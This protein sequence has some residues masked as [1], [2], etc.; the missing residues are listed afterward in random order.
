MKQLHRI[1]RI[2]CLFAFLIYAVT[3]CS[4]CDSA[5]DGPTAEELL[6]AKRQRESEWIAK[7]KTP[8]ERLSGAKQFVADGNPVAAEA[9]LRP[10]LISIP[11]NPSVL[12]IWA[13]IQAT[14]GRKTQ[15]IETLE[16]VDDS[17]PE[18]KAQALW[19]ASQWLIDLGEFTRAENSLI[20]LIALPGDQSEAL[21]TLSTILNN[22]GRRREA[23]VH[24]ESLAKAGQ[25][26]E[27]ELIAMITLGNPFL[28]QSMPKPD[29]GSDLVPALLVMSREL[30]S[31]GDFAGAARLTAKLAEAFPESTQI[32][33]FLG[34]VYSDQQDNEKLRQWVSQVPSGIEIEAEYWHA[35]GILM[36]LE[37]RPREAVRCFLETVLRDQTNRPAYL[38][39]AQLLK[40]LGQDE[41]A[42]ECLQRSEAI[43]ETSKI[44]R[45]LGFERG[46]SDQLHRIADLL[47]QLRRP[48]E[49][50]A[51]RLIALKQQGAD[52][53]EIQQLE[54]SRQ[55]LLESIE[56][57]A[58]S[59]RTSEA[60]LLCGLDRTQWP[61]PAQDFSAQ[62]TS[63]SLATPAT[64]Q[65]KAISLVNISNQIGLDFQYKNGQATESNELY[66]HQVTG[67]GVGVIDYDLDGWPDLYLTQGGGDAFSDDSNLEDE[68]FRNDSG[69][70]WQSIG[71]A[72]GIDNLGYGQGVA[73][74]DLNQDGWLDIL[75]AN[76]GVNVLYQNNGD[77]SFTRRKLPTHPREGGGWTTSIACG[78]ITGDHLPEIIETNYLDDLSGLTV[79]C[80]SGSI[81]CNPAQF[82]PAADCLLSIQP[83]GSI[84]WNETCAGMKEKSNYGFGIVIADFDQK[85]GNEV[86]ITN[87]TRNNHYWVR[88]NPSGQAGVNQLVE[89]ASIL[90]CAA[91]QN[92][93]AR[94]CMGIAFGDFDRNL[95]LDLYVTNFW[96]QAADLYLL[97]PNGSFTPGNYKLGLFEDS[98]DTVGWGAQAADFDHD[99]WLDLAVL[100]G[101]VTDLSQ[102][103]QPYEMRPQLFQGGAGGFNAVQPDRRSEPNYWTRPALG[104][105]L[106]LIDW[107][108]DGR[109]DLIAN[110]LDQPIALL[111]NQ[112][113]TIG[114]NSIRIELV[115]TLSE[116]DAIGATVTVK[117]R[118]ESWRAWMTGGDGFLCSN[119]NQLHFGVGQ[120]STV[121][122]ITIHWPTGLEQTFRNLATDETY[123]AVEG[124]DDLMER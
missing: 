52:D 114:D 43:G 63:P 46:T 83:D 102:R 84:V 39:L 80:G 78:D 10:L 42:Q 106:A 13:E 96:K 45:S 16:A 71:K 41:L 17:E 4:G 1:W 72:A 101:H 23:G 111:E 77:G 5:S 105:T 18:K 49:S 73:A 21:R 85:P 47:E 88:Q 24:L 97:Q 56:Q 29:F 51:W 54:K 61:L 108:Q 14:S 12:L 28:D 40:Q 11:N 57:N 120:R 79:S 3:L 58:E 66:I 37:N 86:F 100:N 32:Q 122:S 26:Q 112:T 107:N 38:A 103:G 87:D 110:H 19:K 90:G 124:Q 62:P 99:G 116:R 8:E 82:I 6:Q 7:A 75:V 95:Q 64:G 121:E 22:Q 68:L 93:L 55:E 117:D 69:R 76:L 9:E 59:Q 30:K 15:A 115:G 94:G 33:A 70:R 98:V 36:E 67:G 53:S 92:G 48:W 60:F 89:S 25:I 65:T 31:Q 20:E 2:D 91:S 27:K 118:D 74:A 123:L 34:R 35:L 104:R 109:M 50:F 81:A 113:E 44:A 119:Q